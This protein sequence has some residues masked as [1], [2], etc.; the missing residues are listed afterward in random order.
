[1][2][3]LVGAVVGAVVGAWVVVVVDPYLTP[4]SM[5]PVEVQEVKTLVNTTCWPDEDVNLSEIGILNWAPAV[6]TKYP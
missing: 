5:T 4:V 3:A 1:V 6:K 2:G